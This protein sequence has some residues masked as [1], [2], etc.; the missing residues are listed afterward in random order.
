MLAGGERACETA[1]NATLVV[2]PRGMH[3][4]KRVKAVTMHHGMHTME[5]DPLF[6]VILCVGALLQFLD[7]SLGMGYGTA[8]VIILYLLGFDPSRTVFPIL[9]AGVAGGLVS[10]LFHVLFKNITMERESALRRVQIKAPGDDVKLYYTSRT[11]SKDTRVVLIFTASGVLAA[12][13]GVFLSIAIRGLDVAQLVMKVY[14]AV[15][16]LVL[17]IVM[18][19]N[20]KERGFS[21]KIIV[22]TALIGGF[23]KSVSGGGFG[24]VVTAGQ[25]MSGREGK[26]AV[27]STS[28]AE[29][30]ISLVGIALYSIVELYSGQAYALIELVLPLTIGGCVAAPFS[31][32][33]ASRVAKERLKRYITVALVVLAVLMLVKIIFIDGWSS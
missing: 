20:V 28:V 26:Q 1:G 10:S 30:V 29:S 16:V 27:A 14:I 6:M 9:V 24:P 15:L 23:N 19:M 5:I 25:V 2:P 33:F 18:S 22:I 12:I 4:W 3:E 13:T 21:L 32:Y 7:S 11:M 8:L 31:S 17:G